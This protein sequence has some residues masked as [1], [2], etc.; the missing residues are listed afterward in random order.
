MEGE[1]SAQTSS[2]KAGG[3]SSVH[4]QQAGPA[5]PG[6]PYKARGPVMRSGIEIESVEWHSRIEKD[7]YAATVFVDLLTFIYVAVFYQVLPLS[8]TLHD[9]T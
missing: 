3:A 6:L 9:M 2:S 7:W 4:G 1:A 5:E 8:Q